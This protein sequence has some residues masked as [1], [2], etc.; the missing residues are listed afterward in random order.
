MEELIEVIISTTT[1]CIIALGYWGLAI[2]MAIESANIP[3][4]SEVIL[5]FGGYLVSIGKLSFW[6]AVMAGTVGGTVGSVL[7]YYAGLLG[8]RPFLL[9]Y[10]RYI[11]ITE[12]KLAFADSWFEKYGEATAFF[13]RLM[14]VIRTFI[15]LPAGISG[16]DIKKFTVYTF[17]GSLPWSIFL[18]YL[19]VKLGENWTNLKPW[20]HRMDALIV[21]AIIA[22]II[23]YF[24]RK[25][26]TK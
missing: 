25:K 16:M 13:T 7:S 2:G 24:Y 21:L 10:G 9:R 17:L 26:R 14:P 23:Y 12:K 19:G 4:P 20:F 11:G 5:P 22:A 8:G 18:V 6:G 15:S 3:L 1:S